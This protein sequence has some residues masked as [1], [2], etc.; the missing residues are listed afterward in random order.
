MIMRMAVLGSFCFCIVFVVL[1][2]THFAGGFNTFYSS[3]W[4]NSNEYDRRLTLF[5]ALSEQWRPGKL[6]FSLEGSASFLL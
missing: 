2:L 4:R 5:D 1:L 6:A 3:Y